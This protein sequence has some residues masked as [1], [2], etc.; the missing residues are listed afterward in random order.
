MFAI[1]SMIPLLVWITDNDTNSAD[2]VISN[3]LSE[4]M[5]AEKKNMGV[6]VNNKTHEKKKV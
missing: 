3:A 4:T 1:R 5:G 6:E 2:R